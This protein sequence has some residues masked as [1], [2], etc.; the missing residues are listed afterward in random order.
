[1]GKLI[2]LFKI[3]SAIGAIGFFWCFGNVI[4]DGYD[5]GVE[6][7]LIEC[8][9]YNGDLSTTGVLVG[10]RCLINGELVRYIDT[11]NGWKLII[12][13]VNVLLDESGGKDGS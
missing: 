3:I 10:S 1:M 12:N 2:L 7:Q 8:E 4:Q 5:N 9:K 6:E 13:D 11:R